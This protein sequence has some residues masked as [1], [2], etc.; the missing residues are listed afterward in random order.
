M[1]SFV[2]QDEPKLNSKARA[3]SADKSLWQ[4]KNEWCD[5]GHRLV[6]LEWLV[7]KLQCIFQKLLDNAFLT[8][9]K[10]V[11]VEDSVRLV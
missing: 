3:P 10:I 5:L 8:C 7:E 6:D 1:V 11:L 9:N 2:K 4:V